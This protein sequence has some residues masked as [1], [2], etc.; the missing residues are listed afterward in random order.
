MRSAM[1]ADHDAETST[2]LLGVGTESVW[3]P[4]YKVNEQRD[5]NPYCWHNRRVRIRAERTL[6]QGTALLAQ[7]HGPLPFF[8]PALYCR[9]PAEC[10]LATWPRNQWGADRNWF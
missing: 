1:V 4:R 7:F 3:A 5:E 2:S 10:L 8:E 9:G 6:S